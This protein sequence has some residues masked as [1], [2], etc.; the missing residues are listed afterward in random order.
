MS[1]SSAFKNLINP[2]VIQKIASEISNVWNP[3]DQREFV[4]IS[5]KMEPLELKA[6]VL[7]ITEEL[8]KHLPE[9]YPKALKVLVK[10]IEKGRLEG[11]ELW[12]F[13]E[14]IGQFGLD[15]FDLSMHAMHSLTQKFTSEF[16]VRPFFVRDHQK[17]LQYFKKWS[18]DKNH[19]VRRWVSEGSR[20]LLPWGMRLPVFIQDPTPTLE[21]LTLLKFDE[22]LYVRKSVAN[23]LNDIS[24]HHPE[25]TVHTIVSWEKNC[26]TEHQKKI[27]WIKRHSLR[28]LIKKG[29]P[30]ALKLMGASGEMKAKVSEIRLMKNT[31]KLGE[32]LEF[33]FTLTSQGKSDQK[34]VIDYVIHFLKSNGSLGNKVFKLKTIKLEPGEKIEI[35][36]SHSMKPI[37]TMK[38]CSGE[39]GL[40][41]QVNGKV[42][43]RKKWSFKA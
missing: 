25:L 3:F 39:Q 14:Y 2:K 17:T 23:H 29:N 8:K 24:K 18:Q 33:S 27:E 10:V 13:S 30:K 20:P 28:T 35:Q 40:S 38:Y 9:S 7:L 43:G 19:H 31:V 15:D 42:V 11:F 1:E 12:P 16:A 4:K 22:E 41:I 36:K 26:P 5:K 32:K 21:L 6:R 37:T 34:L